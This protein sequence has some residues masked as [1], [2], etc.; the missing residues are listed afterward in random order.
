MSDVI[1]TL[2]KEAIKLLN[3]DNPLQAEQLLIKAQNMLD[4]T[5]NCGKAIDRNLIITILYN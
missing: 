5:A 3:S 4:F 2:N 1:E